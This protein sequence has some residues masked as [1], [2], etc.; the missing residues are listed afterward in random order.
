M[1]RR[2]VLAVVLLAIA[3]VALGC[4]RGERGAAPSATAPPTASA[5]PSA[6]GV[7]AGV[8]VDIERLDFELAR[9][10]AAGA[11][12]SARG[13]FFVW[14]GGGPPADAGTRPE[15]ANPQILDVVSLA[16]RR[17]APT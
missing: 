6:L 15:G 7:V 16:S 17:Q 1:P 8:S 4:K 3:S 13:R 2:N 14:G 11:V 5:A 10:G 12:D 9:F